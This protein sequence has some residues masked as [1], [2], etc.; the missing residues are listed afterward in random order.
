MCGK[1]QATLSRFAIWGG[2]FFIMLATVDVTVESQA[3][4]LKTSAGGIL[5]ATRMLRQDDASL[6]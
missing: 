4:L 3:I 6:G 1:S 5:S 2:F